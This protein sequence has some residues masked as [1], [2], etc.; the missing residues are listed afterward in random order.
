MLFLV[1]CI[2]LRGEKFCFVFK[3][4]DEMICMFEDVMYLFLLVIVIVSVWM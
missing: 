1:K 2:I 3:N 4:I